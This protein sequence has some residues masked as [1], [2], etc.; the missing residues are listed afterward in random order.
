MVEDLRVGVRPESIE[1]D[2]AGVGHD[3]LGCLALVALVPTI[4]TPRIELAGGE[5]A[6]R[7][8]QGATVINNIV[9]HRNV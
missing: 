3:P 9:M 5:L 8:G 1:N 7:S 6:R 2:G 4:L